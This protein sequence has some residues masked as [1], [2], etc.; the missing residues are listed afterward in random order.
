MPIL[1]IIYED[2]HLIA[3]NKP[4]GVL[5]QEDETGD[6][7]LTDYVKDY[8]KQRYD[9]PGEV[10]LGVIHRLDRPV[11]GVV[12]FART[13]KAL[14]RMNKLFHDRKVEKVYWAIAGHRPNPLKGSLRHFLTKDREKN[15][16]RVY[17]QISNRN[18]DGKLSEL[19]YE[20]IGELSG[21]YLIEVRP[22]TGRPHQIRAQLAKMGWPI[23]GD[24]KYGFPKANPDGNIHLHC[25]KLAFEHPIKL[26]Q[27]EIM[28]DPPQDPVWNMFDL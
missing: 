26:E 9:K 7:P 22:H 16:A 6:K 23:R 14:E 2:N 21:N 18:P 25:R 1:Q 20:L 15:M 10:F 28:A 5:V 13:S 4:A 19:D 24:L 12:I 27:V 17:D 11:S 8:I 3:G